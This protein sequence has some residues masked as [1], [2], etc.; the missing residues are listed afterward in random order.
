MRDSSFVIPTPSLLAEAVKIISDM[1]IKEQNRDTPGELYEYLL[2]QLQTAG[3][4]GQFRTPRHIIRMM[5]E[6]LDPKFGDRICDP[7]CGTAGFLVASY[8]HILRG[9][10]SKDLL[11]E[12]NLAG[13]K[14]NDAQW[15]VLREE[16]LYGYDFD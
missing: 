7:A 14:M 2:S 3:K 6:I 12:N 16:S 8:E 9:N 15:Q 4:N 13:D 11:K 1:H 10:T 5:I